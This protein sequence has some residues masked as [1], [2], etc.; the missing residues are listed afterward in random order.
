MFRDV[1][2]GEHIRKWVNNPGSANP[3]SA[4]DRQ[5][6]AFRAARDR[7]VPVIAE[8]HVAQVDAFVDQMETMMNA[9]RELLENLMGGGK[10]QDPPAAPESPPQ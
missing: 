10:P 6:A 2:I 7:V 5:I 8:D 3:S 1:I 9:Q 4:I